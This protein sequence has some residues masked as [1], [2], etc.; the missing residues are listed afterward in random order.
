MTSPKEKSLQTLINEADD[1]FS[2]YVRCFYA[3]D[4]GKI[5]CSCGCGAYLPWKQMQNGHFVVRGNNT[6]RW[7]PK[8]AAPVT[9]HCN[10]FDPSQKA[11]IGIFINRVF[12]EGTT[13]EIEILGKTTI[14]LMRF[15]VE[16]IRDSYKLKFNELK[17][18][19]GL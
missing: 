15:E 17:K 9:V 14:K 10:Y 18:A 13:D 16:E 2:L 12:G 3:D 4:N 19:K 7:D 11:K 1:A 8:N 6:V 5:R